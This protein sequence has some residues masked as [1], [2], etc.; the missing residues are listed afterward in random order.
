MADDKPVE[1][2]PCD[3]C[4]QL[5]NHPMIHVGPYVWQKDDRTTLENPSFHFDCLPDALV[6]EFGLNGDDPRHAVTQAARKKAQSGVH[7]DKLRT[8]IQ[9]QKSD[10]DLPDQ[11]A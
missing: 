3:G 7:G 9:S 6:S 10:N 11:E 5:D 2:H 1:N 4:G 8:F